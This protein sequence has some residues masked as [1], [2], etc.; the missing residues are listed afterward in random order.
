MKIFGV[1]IGE[2][3]GGSGISIGFIGVIFCFCGM[4]GII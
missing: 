3:E 1:V 4:A 2:S